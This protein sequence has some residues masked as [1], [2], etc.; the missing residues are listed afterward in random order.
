MKSFLVLVLVLV[1][2][3]C[4]TL[5][6]GPDEP[7]PIPTLF[8]PI[9]SKSLTDFDVARWDSTMS[10]PEVVIPDAF[11]YGPPAKGK[12]V[13]VRRL[14][15]SSAVIMANEDGSDQRTLL[16]LGHF[17]TSAT[18]SPNGNFVAFV[19]TGTLKMLPTNGGEPVTI[20]TGVSTTNQVRWSPKL[21]LLAFIQQNAMMVVAM[22]G[23]PPRLVSTKIREARPEYEDWQW[24]WDGIHMGYT[25]ATVANIVSI[26]TGNDST[27][28][29]IRDRYIH[30]LAGS[31]A[32]VRDWYFAIGSRIAH[33][34]HETNDVTYVHTSR[35]GD[36]PSFL[37]VSPKDAFISFSVVTA[38]G[39][40]NNTDPLRS[41]IKVLR[42]SDNT[43][44]DLGVSGS[45][46]YW[47]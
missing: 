14:K 38:T 30:T 25:Y 28:F 31:Q 4:K 7:E 18:L 10:A 47:R 35:N 27:V 34:Q 21:N 46:G 16:T 26:L 5:P 19:Y 17:I 24:S 42:R 20:A 22:D 44:I 23:Q 43:V 2:V 13:V 9:L 29:G 15:D 39:G 40:N 36:Y 32:D 1:T 6:T 41:P 8:V 45:K 37:T 12:I 3:G 33:Y 11:I